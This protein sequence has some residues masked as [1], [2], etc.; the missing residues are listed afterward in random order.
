M[1][2]NQVIVSKETLPALSVEEGLLLSKELLNVREEVKDC[3]YLKEA[4][5]VLP[6]QG[7]RSAIGAY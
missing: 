4:L 6:V 1:N 7:Y 3:P 2:T 5:K